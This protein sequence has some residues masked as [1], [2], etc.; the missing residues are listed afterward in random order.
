MTDAVFLL[1]MDSFDEG[2]KDKFFSIKIG[3]LFPSKAD[4]LPSPNPANATRIMTIAVKKSVRKAIFALC[5][6]I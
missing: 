5:L 3:D 1:D 2:D 4:S 6:N